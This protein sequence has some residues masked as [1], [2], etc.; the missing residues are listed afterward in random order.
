MIRLSGKVD[1]VVAARD[2]I[3]YP[4][5]L[6]NPAPEAPTENKFVA[7]TLAPCVARLDT[8]N[9]PNGAQVPS[10]RKNVDAEAFEP[11][12]ICVVEIL[13]VKTENGIL[14]HVSS[15][16]QNVVADAFAPLFKFV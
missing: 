15:P 2:T 4:E 13:P 14:D 11:L 1:D 9:V 12:F 16:R 10:P 6:Y 7:A 8:P 3:M 5:T